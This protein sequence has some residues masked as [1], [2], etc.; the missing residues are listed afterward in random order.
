MKKIF[1]TLLA[2]SAILLFAGVTPAQAGYKTFTC[3]TVC[4]SKSAVNATKHKVCAPNA[5][6]A[7]MLAK[8]HICACTEPGSRLEQKC[9]NKMTCEAYGDKPCK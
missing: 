7:K 9:V 8:P 6:Y 2:L 3:V 1:V 5:E 4:Q